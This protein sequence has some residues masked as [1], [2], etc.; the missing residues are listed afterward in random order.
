MC[1]RFSKCEGE[2]QRGAERS[3]C[4]I[5]NGA[6]QRNAQP[7]L[8]EVHNFLGFAYRS[9][10]SYSAKRKTKRKYEEKGSA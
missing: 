4:R 8:A 2:A 10:N 6:E 3:S 7:A 1:L 5:E 9:E